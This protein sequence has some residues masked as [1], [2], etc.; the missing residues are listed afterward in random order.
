VSTSRVDGPERIRHDIQ[1]CTLCKISSYC[2]H[3][4][5]WRLGITAN[6]K[7]IWMFCGEAPGRTEHIYESPFMGESGHILVKMMTDA[8]MFM[9]SFPGVRIIYTNAVACTPFDDETQLHIGTPNKTNIDNCRQY[10]KRQIDYY[11]PS[12]IFAIGLVAKQSLSKLGADFVHLVHPASIM[13]QGSKG[14][15]DYTSNVLKIKETMK[16][17]QKRNK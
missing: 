3:K 6:H 8:G 12:N 11:K 7:D 13:R 1:K 10:L 17:W 15:L 9:P 4:V 5:T 14:N 16:K 2:N